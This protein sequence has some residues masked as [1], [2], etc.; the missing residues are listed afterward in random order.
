MKSTS[1]VWRI[2]T[3]LIAVMALAFF[4]R[5]LLLPESFGE[6]GH[7]RADSL[8]EIMSLELVHQGRQVCGDCHAEIY[9]LHKKDIHFAVQCEDCHGPGNLHVKYHQTTDHSISENQA[10]MPK[11]YTLEGCL[12][13]HRK[14]AARPRSFAQIDPVEHYEF[15]HVTD[16]ET[17]CIECHSP[18]EP[19]FLLK[20]VD[21]ARLHPVIF[22]CEDCHDT[23]PQ[24]DHTE[25]PDHPVVFVCRDCH[26]AIVEDFMQH[27]H[28]FLRCT[29]CHLF[30]QTSD[31]AGRLFN[32]GNWR[33]CLL[34]HEDKPFKD[35]DKLPQLVY[36]DHLSVMAKHMCRDL[37]TLQDEPSMCLM[38]HRDKDKDTLPPA[39][40]A[41]H[42]EKMAEAMRGGLETLVKDPTVCLLCHFDYIHDS[43]LLKKPKERQP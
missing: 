1:H 41:D 15:L 18:H 11:E 32:N 4:A 39:S 31:T 10:R 12:F 23:P 26:P 9:E 34:C 38:C 37:D 33:F 13:C 16:S 17:P 29:T 5:W 20:E 2:F 24:K 6:L 3:A 8:Q 28:S 22:E 42:L 43:V 7:Y 25:V 36:A 19:L 35:N 27:E 14:L 30:Y 21:Q 40:T